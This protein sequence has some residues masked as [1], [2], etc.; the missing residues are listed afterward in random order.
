MFSDFR[1]SWDRASNPQTTTVNSSKPPHFM[2]GTRSTWADSITVESE[3]DVESGT[4]RRPGLLDRLTGMLFKARTLKH[5][6]DPDVVSV[7]PERLPAWPPLHIEK[8]APQCCEHC[9]GQRKKRKR[10]RILLILLIIVLLYLIGNTAAL[11]VRTF[12]LTTT[13]PSSSSGSSTA[14]TLSAD[15][16]LCLSEFNI[17]APANTTL[18]PCSTCFSVL[19]GVSESYLDAHTQ[20]A[21]EIANAIQFCSLRSMFVEADS[22]GQNQ[23]TT[24]GWM[25]SVQFCGWTG[26]Q[27]NT[28]G[29]VTSLQ[30]TFPAVPTVIPEEIGGLTG[31]QTL[32]IVGNTEVPAGAL[33]TSFTNLTALSTLEFQST[34]ITQLPNSLFTSLKNITTLTLSENAQMGSTLPSSLTDL[35]LQNLVVTNQALQNPLSVFVNSTSFRSAMKLLDLSTTTLSGTIPATI[36]SL[37]SLVELHLDNNNLTS[38]L[39]TAFPAKLELLTLAN[40]TQLSGSVSGSFCSLSD[41][42]DCDMQGTALKA[43]GSC[44]V[45]QFS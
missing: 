26:V 1:F 12:P 37:S 13:S 21:Q 27:C 42:Q 8:R 32:Q 4:V 45:C 28:S 5:D 39:P 25:Q 15:E 3:K 40:N 17:N 14:T 23:L 33:P 22:T 10:D 36:S 24:G 6:Q 34:A 11:N 20:D 44:G 18:Y 38:P 9:P 35:P 43:A 41:L 16:Q 31:L 2:T 30:L 29:K 19:Q 7:Q